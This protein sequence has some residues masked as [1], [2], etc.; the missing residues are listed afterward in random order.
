MHS[1]YFPPRLQEQIWLL[2]VMEEEAGGESRAGRAH[3]CRS[4]RSL[5]HCI[6]AATLSEASR[7][8]NKSNH[9][10]SYIPSSP[11]GTVATW[12]A[13]RRRTRCFPADCRRPAPTK[14]HRGPNVSLTFLKA[15]MRGCEAACQ[16]DNNYRNCTIQQL[17][18]S[19]PLHTSVALGKTHTGCHLEP[20]SRNHPHISKLILARWG[21]NSKHNYVIVS[22]QKKKN[23]QTQKLALPGDYWASQPYCRQFCWGLECSLAL[24]VQESNTVSGNT[25]RN[26]VLNE[27]LLFRFPPSEV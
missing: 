6:S 2:Q 9:S 13:E 16:C 14:S 17:Q 27:L 18:A 11:M 3:Q 22:E 21:K 20:L 10:I 7:L 12:L 8:K 19:H 23:T 5:Y 26:S 15:L 1:W 24:T 4:T 25:R